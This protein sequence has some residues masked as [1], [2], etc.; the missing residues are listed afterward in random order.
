[1]QTGVLPQPD[2]TTTGERLAPLAPSADLPT[3]VDAVRENGRWYMSAAYTALEYLR[4]EKNV[5]AAD[6]GSGARAIA[7]LA[8]TRPTRSQD[9]ARVAPH[10]WAS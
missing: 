10:D 4:E 1:M 6:F 2:S 3:F 8:P 5:S 7:T 9:G